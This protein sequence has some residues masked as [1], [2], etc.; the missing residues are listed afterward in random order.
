MDAGRPD[1][2][3]FHSDSLTSLP[4]HQPSYDPA[5]LPDVNEA[6][7]VR[8]AG[9]NRGHGHFRIARSGK[10]SPPIHPTPTN[11]P[12][13]LSTHTIGKPRGPNL[14]VRWLTKKGVGRLV[15][16]GLEPRPRVKRCDSHLWLL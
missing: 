4:S 12:P 7:E 15:A 10:S 3:W 5:V 9:A 14:V 6:G 11:D 16:E 13:A 2:S 8:A 1:G